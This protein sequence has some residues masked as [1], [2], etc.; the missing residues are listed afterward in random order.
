MFECIDGDIIIVVWDWMLR[1]FEARQDQAED[2][3]P[4]RGSAG[5]SGLASERQA[6]CQ[7]SQLSQ[8]VKSGSGVS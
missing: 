7:L 1:S 5:G 3:R 6:G 4:A 2:E 8:A